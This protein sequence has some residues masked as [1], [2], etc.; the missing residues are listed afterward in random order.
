MDAQLNLPFGDLTLLGLRLIK[1]GFEHQPAAPLRAGDIAHLTLFWR[2]DQPPS[3][4]LSLQLNLRD[5]E[6]TTR[7]EHHTPITTGQHPAFSWRAGE[8][9]RDQHNLPLPSDLQP[10]R[11]S[12]TIAAKGL[13][14]G[15]PI[16]TP[17]ALAGLTISD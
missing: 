4:D 5:Q 3:E 1:L 10:G 11:Y 8:I 12:L 15:R 7:L 14:S 6:G 16:G 2:A 9:I 17:Q 13:Q